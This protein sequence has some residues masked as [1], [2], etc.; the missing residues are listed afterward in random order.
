MKRMCSGYGYF[1]KAV[2]SRTL[3]LGLAL[4]LMLTCGIPS[5]HATAA[6][7]SSLPDWSK[8]GYKGGQT[9]PSGG[10]VIDM[11]T[12]GVTANGGDDTT[13]IQKVIDDIRSGALKVNGS[14]VSESNRVILQFPAGQIDINKQIRVDAS[15]IT[16]RGAGNDPVT[17]TRFVFKPTAT[18]SEDPARPGAPLIDGKLWPGY[19]AFRVEDRAKHSG[20]TSYEGSIN[21]HWLAG[22]RVANAGGGSKGSTQVKLASGK[23]SGFKA[24]DTIY[25]GAANTVA[26]YD[27]MQAPQSYRINQHMRSQM[28]KVVSVSGDT[29][30][31]DKP[32]EFDVP[33]SNSGQL[34]SE[35]GGS[36][37]TYYSKVMKV[38]AVK[39][40]GFENFYFTQ[41]IAYTPYNGQINANDYDA[42][43]NPGGVGLRYQNAALEYALHG[44]LFKWAQDGW[45]KG[46]RT[47]MTGSHPIVTEFAKNMEFQNNV[48]FGSWNKGAGGHGYFRAS[49]LYDSRIVGNTIDRIRHLALQ[50]SATNNVVQGNTMSVDMNLHGGWERRNLIEQNTINVPFDHKSWG[51]GEGGLDTADG[52]TWYPLWYGAGP[53]ASK[54]SGATG[55]QNVVFN[56][57]LNKQ[58]TKGGSYVAYTPYNS[59]TTIYQIGWDGSSWTHLQKP[60]G[61][62]IPSWGGNEKVNFSASPNKGVYACLTFSGASLLGSGTATNSCT[63]GGGDTQ[64][65][66]APTGLTAAAASSSQINLAWTASTDN[67]GVTGYDVYRNGTFLKTVSGTSTNDTGLTA[68]TA[69][70]YY[71]KARDGAGNLSVASN[72]VSATTLSGGGGGM[73]TTLN[74]TDDSYV[75]QS[76]ATKNYGSDSMM[77]IK[78]SSGSDRAAYL[79]FN[80]S[81]VST[82]SS[83]KLRVYVKSSAN[84]TLTALQTTDSWTEGA[85]TWN[86][87]PS[88]G[89]TIGSAS[90]STTFKYVEIDVTSYVQAQASG[91]HLASFVLTESA[92]KYT[93]INSSEN[94]SNKPE[95][96]II[97]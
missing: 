25:V 87:K 64:A 85:L 40:V 63:G 3:L 20:D 90:V 14:M 66:T 18:Y 42:V 57:T 6:V 75:Y 22:E 89:S 35:E 11:T 69:Y 49:K 92:G 77:Y 32:L 97:N 9:L 7:D 94:S 10:T 23:G 46:V 72:T 17:G 37:S 91:D 43:T 44:I 96:I 71:V 52:S 26:F 86:N 93:E 62:F 24:G 50:W 82:V 56:N 34:P 58:E 30:T 51:E 41:D 67:V 79:K 88:S 16:I 8:S 19:A 95:L 39:G 60:T 84:T 2:V 36:N 13:S 81:G 48:I 15:Y 76:N 21:F 47:Y 65:P 55:E 45:V 5:P 28:F 33:F 31:I 83:A 74:P 54:W 80:L 73:S 68:N 61:T 4:S 12:K 53:H 78:T 38:T 70:S 27:Q 59:K 1:V 29:L